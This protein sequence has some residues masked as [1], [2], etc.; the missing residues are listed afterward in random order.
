MA[1]S[2]NCKSNFKRKLRPGVTGK[3]VIISLCGI[4][5]NDEVLNHAIEFTGEGVKHLSIDE[6]LTIANMTTE[7]GALAGVF[8]IDEITI[9]WLKRR[10]EVISATGF[11]RSYF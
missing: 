11:R 4:F 10:D 7:W 1:S 5:N 3:D 8:P 9:E 6:R 2:T